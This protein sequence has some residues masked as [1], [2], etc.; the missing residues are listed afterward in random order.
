MEL[1][2]GSHGYVDGFTSLD[3]FY[4]DLS[5][6]SHADLEGSADVLIVDASG[7]SHIELSE[8]SVEDADIE[9][10]GGSFGTINVSGRL[11]ADVSG[12]S[13]LTYIGDPILGDIVQ[14]SGSTVSMK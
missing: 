9:L 4:L 12:G 3:E 2:G 10:S 6:G 5:G 7:G 11:D 8:F 1:S 14:T 13:H